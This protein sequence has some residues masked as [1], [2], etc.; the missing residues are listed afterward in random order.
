MFQFNIIW[1]NNYY[2]DLLLFNSMGIDEK[3]Y[4]VGETAYYHECGIVCRVEVL[5][6]NSDKDVYRYKLKVLNCVLSREDLTL[7]KNP[8]FICCKPRKWSL[9]VSG[10]WS[11]SDNPVRTHA[12]E[13]LS[14]F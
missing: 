4:A 7:P 6:N 1:Y 8:E 10:W 5:E 2:K 11:L 12:P 3:L 14:I 13:E 9:G